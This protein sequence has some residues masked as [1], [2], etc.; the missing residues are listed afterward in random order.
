MNDRI[1]EIRKVLKI[2][3]TAF[4][5]RLGVKQ[6]TVANYENGSRQPIDAVISSICREFHVNETWLRT[7]EGEM[8]LPEVEDDLA[9]YVRSRGASELELK[10]IRA[11]FDLDLDTR[12]ELIEHFRTRIGND[13][14]AQETIDG[15]TREEYHAMIDRE[16]DAKEKK[17]EPPEAVGI[18]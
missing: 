7:G 15:M 13:T 16:F 14:P 12:R 5:D 2:N 17:G 3:Q 4:G 10:I 11:Y 9:E 1:K 18:A 8:F 6:T